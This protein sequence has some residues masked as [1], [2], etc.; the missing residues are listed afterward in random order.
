MI[1]THTIGM[2]PLTVL[3]VMTLTVTLMTITFERVSLIVIGVVE[4]RSV[5]VINFR[6]RTLF[7]VGRGLINECKLSVV[8]DFRYCC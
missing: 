4:T 6:D 2:V 7:T 8:R 5:V 3:I 1:T